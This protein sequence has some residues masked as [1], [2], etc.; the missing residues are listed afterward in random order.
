[1][2]TESPQTLQHLN[3]LLIPSQ[4]NPES[5]SN[6]DWPRLGNPAIV[7]NGSY[8]EL[9]VIGPANISSWSIDLYR[10]YSEYTITFDS[11]IRNASTGI[12]HINASIPSNTLVDLFDLR[13]S[14]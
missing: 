2:G 10:E 1:M 14:V 12:W 5:P 3:S 6:I 4:Y 8:V 7:L 11:P 13:I 9:R